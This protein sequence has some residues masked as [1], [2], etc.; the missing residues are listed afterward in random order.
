MRGHGQQ[1]GATVFGYRVRDPQRYGVAEFDAAKDPED[2]A[3]NLAAN[4]TVEYAEP[5]F[6]AVALS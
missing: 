4:E 3:R 5:N 2:I 6:V 1:S